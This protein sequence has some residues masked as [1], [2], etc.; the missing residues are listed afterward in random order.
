LGKRT[1]LENEMADK[2]IAQRVIVVVLVVVALVILAAL[3]RVRGDTDQ[4]VIGITQIAT[5][6]S[7]D[8][9]RKGV[10]EALA[11]RG[12]EDGQAIR[13]VFRNAQG[14]PSL[15]LPIAQDFVRMPV[16]VIV[17]ITTPSAMAAA[18]STDSI[19]IV[20]GGVTD[21]VGIG[22]VESMERPG[23]NITGTS[24]Q[25]PFEEQFDFFHVL[26]PEVK[27]IAMLHQPG[28]DVSRLGVEAARRHLPTLGIELDVIHVSDSAQ[29]LPAA[30]RALRDADAIYTGIDN[31]V[32]ENLESVL[33]VAREADKPVF[34][35][36]MESVQRGA[37]AAVAVSMRDLGRLT[38]ELVVEILDG[39][40]PGELQVRTVTSGYAVVNR[41]AINRFGLD[42]ESLTD[43]G[44]RIIDPK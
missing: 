31:L 34:A 17:A 23:R 1:L 27:R 6:P 11:E 19:P 37:T 18:R 22:L 35:G 25:W 16:D 40:V 33:R 2:K 9:V 7:L 41:H 5:H 39:A 12:F 36:D 43:R 29:I 3:L 15:A 28:D 30:T 14:D 32:A 44:I 42:E 24:D 20:F 21:P 38:G 10:L 4:P 8:E 13:V 26:F